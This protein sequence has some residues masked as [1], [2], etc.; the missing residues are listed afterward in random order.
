MSEV[1]SLQDVTNQKTP[2]VQDDGAGS[3]QLGPVVS[4]GVTTG[5]LSG[6]IDQKQG[7]VRDERYYGKTIEGDN[8]S[9]GSGDATVT[10]TASSVQNTEEDKKGAAQ[11]ANKEAGKITGA[12]YAQNLANIAG[13][14]D[15]TVISAAIS[16][17]NTAVDNAKVSQGRL[18]ESVED[19]VVTYYEHNN[20]NFNEY[21]TYN[22][23]NCS[24][25]DNSV[26]QL[27]GVTIQDRSGTPFIIYD[28]NSLADGS[29]TVRGDMTGAEVA[30]H[31]WAHAFLD[32]LEAPHNG[33]HHAIMTKAGVK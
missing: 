4:D 14:T 3:S 6:V 30:Q 32:V 5:Y 25:S 16:K 13:V 10:G 28:G 29:K 12:T 23:R 22:C 7:D 33:Q 1:N 15:T 17:A 9:N 24:K 31:E 2:I 20:G 8:T 21:I 27:G 11:L 19:G 18:F 26:L